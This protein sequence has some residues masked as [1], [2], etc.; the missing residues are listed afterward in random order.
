MIS[1]TVEDRTTP[2]WTSFDEGVRLGMQKD[3]EAVHSYALK[4]REHYDA[5][6]R[7]VGIDRTILLLQAEA[8]I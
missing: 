1:N 8:G 7:D 5:L 6:F 2:N 3:Y 4:R